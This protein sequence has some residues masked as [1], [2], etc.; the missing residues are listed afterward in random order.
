MSGLADPGARLV[1]NRCGD[2]LALSPRSG[3]NGPGLPVNQPEGN[4]H[5]AAVLK[6]S[7]EL[8]NDPDQSIP[9]ANRRD[10]FC[11]CPIG[12]NYTGAPIDTADHRV[13]ALTV[14]YNPPRKADRHLLLAS[15]GAQVSPPFRWFPT[16]ADA[17]SYAGPGDLGCEDRVLLRDR[18]D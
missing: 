8:I 6:T 3:R 4:Y 17:P 12:G 11:K 14:S 16:A 9:H 15:G 5:I 2:S 10:R 7:N 13:N 18:V 1:R